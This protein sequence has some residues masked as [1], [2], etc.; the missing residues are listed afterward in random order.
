MCI[1]ESYVGLAARTVSILPT[2]DCSLDHRI[3]HNWVHIYE[4]PKRKEGCLIVAIVAAV[5]QRTY[6]V[7]CED[8]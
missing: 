5:Y 4:Q 7:F 6:N 2:N 3:G 1:V 8:Y